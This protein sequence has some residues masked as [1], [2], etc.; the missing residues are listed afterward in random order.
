[1]N[2]PLPFDAFLDAL[3][4]HGF[5]VGLH[6]HMALARLLA[7]WEG[8]DPRTLGASIA[9][10]VARSE[11]EVE[12][13]RRLFEE[14][15][16][17]VEKRGAPAGVTLEP[18]TGRRAAWW[19][20][21][22]A[23]VAGMGL[24]L[25][26]GVLAGYYFEPAPVTPP[27]YDAPPRDPSP[28]DG[29][30][31]TQ[32]PTPPPLPDPP[33]RNA[34]GAI[35]Q[36]GTA[37]FLIALAAAWGIDRR[38][39][40]HRWRDASW[41]RALG[42]LPGPYQIDLHVR[43]LEARLPRADIEDAASI[44]GRIYRVDERT[45]ELDPAASL[46]ETLRRGLLP[47]LVFRRVRTARPIVV[48]QDV[49]LDMALWRAKV[50]RL[51]TDLRRQGVVLERWYF[52]GDPRR[53]STHPVGAHVAL[54]HVIGL[55]P[56][57]PVLVVSSG[58][59]L[60]A[61]GTEESWLR[62]LEG[63]P[64]RAW[65]T[66]VSDERLWPAALRSPAVG[67][68]PMSREG[69]TSAARALAGYETAD[70]VRTQI[71]A[72][73]HVYMDDV[74]R[75]KRLASLVP[76]P[77]AEL[78]EWLRQRFASDVPDAAVAHV[79]HASGS[80]GLREIRL[81]EDDVIRLAAAVHTETPALAR[82]VRQAVLEALRDS[83]P[84]PGSAAHLRWRLAVALQ[85]ANLAASGHGDAAGPRATLE[86][87]AAGPLWEEVQHARA[88]VPEAGAPRA[89]TSGPPLGEPAVGWAPRPRVAPG[90]RQLLLASTA[91]GLVLFLA[92]Q[93]GAFPTTAF[94]RVENAYELRQVSTGTTE[95]VELALSALQPSEPDVVDLYRDGVL[96]QARVALPAAGATRVQIAAGA[97]STY[98]AQALRPDG[99]VA[100]SN[101]LWV[102]D[103][104]RVVVLIDVQPW[105][106]VTITGP[107]D[108]RSTPGTGAT[109][110]TGE[111]TPL[112]V[113]LRPG[114]YR[115]DLENGGVTQPL[116]RDIDVAALNPAQRF[117]FTMPGFD[118]AAA[119]T[120]TPAAAR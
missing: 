2:R 95:S 29:P 55:R 33:A 105:A 101:P 42:A 52:N 93:V 115:V 114:R 79:V 94:A 32:P 43:G 69:L 22:V 30:V 5:A 76:H 65:L 59:G 44:L 67:A 81:A 72:E 92:W 18:A 56:D 25:A 28:P 103:V 98:Q 6:E 64:R 60:P 17:Q 58:G 106:R 19:W 57:S 54:E 120:G 111:A 82:A 118:A 109:Q 74:E 38:R 77:T 88:L 83:E 40:H 41:R 3:R 110:V 49:G 61:L 21:P 70:P 23:A 1:M 89:D 119:A 104:D 80:S 9:A 13:A 35:W 14:L 27:V 68:W 16:V 8:V 113:A 36:T 86:E 66:P 78:L 117:V 7:R 50:E 73:G 26:L 37:L 75:L 62:A 31:A 4:G 100:Q 51:L 99:N 15:Y 10:L 47:R 53:L 96:A 24:V 90:A 63:C 116:Q 45:R 71:L 48:L 97:G 102:P 46:R 108:Q 12:T 34:T 39:V 11:A 91:A 87:L 20:P 84:A 112:R 107:L 85:E